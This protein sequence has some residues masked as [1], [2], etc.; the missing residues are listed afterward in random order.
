MMVKGEKISY[1]QKVHAITQSWQLKILGLS[2]V[3]LSGLG[4]HADLK[5]GFGCEAGYDRCVKSCAHAR[6]ISWSH[7]VPYS[8]KKEDVEGRG[9]R[10]VWRKGGARHHGYYRHGKGYGPH[11]RDFLNRVW[12]E[13]K[14][15]YQQCVSGCLFHYRSCCMSETPPSCVR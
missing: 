11:R 6:E 4:L 13:K 12:R 2:M 9:Y 1:M 3:L 10:R 8:S 14:R 7:G 15:R 5:A